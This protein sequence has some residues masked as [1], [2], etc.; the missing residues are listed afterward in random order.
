MLITAPTCTRPTIVSIAFSEAV[1]QGDSAFAAAR[2]VDSGAI[3]AEVC[4]PGSAGGFGAATS[5][6]TRLWTHEGV[7]WRGQSL[8]DHGTQA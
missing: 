2:T 1:D 3:Y 6:I 4:G 8:M 5:A 7:P